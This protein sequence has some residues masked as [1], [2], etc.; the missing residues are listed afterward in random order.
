MVAAACSIK[1]RGVG[2]GD[3]ACGRSNV[4]GTGGLVS[5]P[6]LQSQQESVRPCLWLQGERVPN[7]RSDL[8]KVLGSD[9]VV[10]LNH[11]G[12]PGRERGGA[13]LGLGLRH[14][15]PRRV[16]QPKEHPGHSERRSRGKLHAKGSRQ[17]VLRR[18]CQLAPKRRLDN[19]DQ[20]SALG[21]VVEELGKPSPALHACHVQRERAL[22]NDNALSL[23]KEGQVQSR[24]LG[25]RLRQV[26]VRCLQRDGRVQVVKVG[27]R[28][29]DA[30]PKRALDV[31]L[32]CRV[33][34]AANEQVRRVVVREVCIRRTN[35]LH[36]PEQGV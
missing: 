23:V 13:R 31:R 20:H 30:L 17:S 24:L 26:A 33:A 29:H 22:R 15:G 6:R 1:I 19:A 14:R 28:D 21:S 18:G 3:G 16:L 7:G 34:L 10:R 11:A 32:R 27:L 25:R 9:H 12:Q 2:H 5:A 36:D 4:K 8:A 35:P